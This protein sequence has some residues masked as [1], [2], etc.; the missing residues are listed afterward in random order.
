MTT[1][2]FQDRCDPLSSRSTASHP[3]LARRR[4][5]ARHRI[6]VL[7]MSHA[8]ASAGVWGYRTG[9][10]TLHTGRD[11][12]DG[13]QIVS[14]RIIA[15][16]SHSDRVYVSRATTTRARPANAILSRDHAFDAD[17]QLEALMPDYVDYRLLPEPLSTAASAAASLAMVVQEAEALDD[18]RQ[19]QRRRSVAGHQILNLSVFSTLSTQ[20]LGSTLRGGGGVQLAG[21]GWLA[22]SCGERRHGVHVAAGVGGDVVLGEAPEAEVLRRLHARVDAGLQHPPRRHGAARLR[23]E[24]CWRSTRGCT[25]SRRA[26]ARSGPHRARPA[27]NEVIQAAAR[28]GGGRRGRSAAFVPSLIA[29]DKITGM[30]ILENARRVCC[31]TGRGP[32]D[33]AVWRRW[34]VG[35]GGVLRRRRLFTRRPVR[36]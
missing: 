21:G 14:K 2:R 6:I 20:P 29:G 33:D 7:E 23:M 36:L 3:V 32:A 24:Q 4:L 13:A 31:T 16:I 19:R 34:P 35:V 26:W 28:R 10:A 5:H 22:S 27:F 17:E 9:V 25:G 12:Q 11:E 18:E 30:A 15:A 1:D 8:S